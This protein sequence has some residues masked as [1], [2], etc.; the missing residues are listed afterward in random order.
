MRQSYLVDLTCSTL[1]AYF[2]A[3]A[4]PNHPIDLINIAFHSTAEGYNTPDRVTSLKSLQEL[5]RLL[6]DRQFRLHLVNVPLSEIGSQNS[7][8]VSL[9]YPNDALMDVT[10]SAPLWFASRGEAAT[11]ADIIYY[12][13]DGATECPA[14]LT[15]QARVLLVGHGAD[16]ILGGYAR[17]RAALQNGGWP[18]L[19]QE[20][21][22]DYSR[23]WKRNLGRDDRVLSDCAREARHPYLDE[24]FSTWIRSLPPWYELWSDIFSFSTHD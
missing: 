18:R 2:A 5:T 6:P 23:L 21:E 4:S 17:H 15:S 1:L 12:P 22:L 20:M 10:I 19:L 13:P 14:P 7:H 11:P 9:M 3:E 16:E 8:I 24:E